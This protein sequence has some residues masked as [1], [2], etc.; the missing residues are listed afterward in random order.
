MLVLENEFPPHQQIQPVGDPG[1]GGLLMIKNIR[2]AKQALTTRLDI[3][4]CSNRD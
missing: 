3:T 2:K 1:T 4:T